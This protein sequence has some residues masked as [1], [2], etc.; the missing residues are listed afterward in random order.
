MWKP[1]QCEEAGLAQS[2]EHKCTGKWSSQEVGTPGEMKQVELSRVRSM[3][4]HEIRDWP[5]WNVRATC[6]R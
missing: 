3:T 2:L 5:V 1:K 4:T 6:L